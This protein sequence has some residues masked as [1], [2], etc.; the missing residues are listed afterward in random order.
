VKIKC[1]AIRPQIL[2]QTLTK[3]MIIFSPD[4][5][6]SD[7]YYYR[8]IEV[9]DYIPLMNTTLKTME[10]LIQDENNRPLPLTKG[11]ASIIKMNLRRV[12][13]TKESFNV[14]ITSEK[15]IEFPNNTNT[16]FTNRLPYPLLLDSSWKV[17]LISV[18]YPA[19]FTTFLKDE[20]T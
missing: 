5:N 3:D 16:E 9:I 14:R 1:D 7:E 2:N 4:F 17:S 10:I 19:K 13:P 12:P 11:Q 15:T 18:N 6:M 8:E 20:N